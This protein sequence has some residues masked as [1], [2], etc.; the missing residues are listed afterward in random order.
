MYREAAGRAMFV[1]V[2]VREA[3]ALDEWVTKDNVADGIEVR[4]PAALDARC[5]AAAAMCG[6]LDVTIPAVAD[7]LDDRVSA[8]YGAWPDRLYVL[9]EAGVVVHKAAVGPFGFKPEDVRQVLMSRWGL[10]LSPT[11]YVPMKLPTPATAP[12]AP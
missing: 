11:Q 7:T 6:R 1:L 4:Q 12:G 9:D 8:L 3:H 10:E 5:D 2:Y